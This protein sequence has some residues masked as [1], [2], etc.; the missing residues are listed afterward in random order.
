MELTPEKQAYSHMRSYAL[1]NNGYFNNYM[2]L[3]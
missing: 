3:Q 2:R 1:P